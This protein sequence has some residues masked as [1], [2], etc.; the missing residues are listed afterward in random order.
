MVLF[1][2]FTELDQDDQIH[3]IKQG[4]FEV[5]LTRDTPLFH[6]DGMFV[7]TME[8]KAPRYRTH[9]HVPGRYMYRTHTHTME[10]K[11]PRYMYRTHTYTMEQKAPRYSTHTHTHTME[12]KAPRYSTHTYTHMYT[13]FS[14]THT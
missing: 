6:E 2:G 13:V 1:A 8:Q 10:Q 4:S 7:P 5:V 3:L 12:Q 14:H 11:A 9:T